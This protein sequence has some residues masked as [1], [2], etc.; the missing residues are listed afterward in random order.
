[1]FG[2]RRDDA[3]G[4]GSFMAIAA[5]LARAS[6]SAKK[7]KNDHPCHHHGRGGGERYDGRGRTDERWVGFIA[8]LAIRDTPDEIPFTPPAHMSF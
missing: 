7:E 8:S 1:M 3:T 5:G 6:L 2:E 4:D